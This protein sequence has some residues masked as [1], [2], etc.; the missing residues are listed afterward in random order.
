MAF[1]ICLIA[2]ALQENW[3][4]HCCDG[5]IVPRS[6]LQTVVRGKKLCMYTMVIQWWKL[7][8]VGFTE[9][10]AWLR[11]SGV[12]FHHNGAVLPA[13]WDQSHPGLVL[14][15]HCLLPTRY[16]M[17]QCCYYRTILS[18]QC[19]PNIGQ[20]LLTTFDVWYWP[21]ANMYLS[22]SALAFLLF[23]EWTVSFHFPQLCL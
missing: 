23:G 6:H 21:C 8:Y 5:S 11:F 10:A 4:W 15:L 14:Y 9:A 19:S 3:P 13:H 16:S 1:T 7:I 18:N 17:C 20:C 2:D 12:V 22:G